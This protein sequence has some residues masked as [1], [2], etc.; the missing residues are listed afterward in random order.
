MMTTRAPVGVGNMYVVSEQCFK[1]T[2]GTIKKNNLAASE[3]DPSPYLHI[4]SRFT[5]DG[6]P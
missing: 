3:G 4:C 6:L 5:A 1:A 2:K